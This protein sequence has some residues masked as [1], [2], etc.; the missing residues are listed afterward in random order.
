MRRPPQYNPLSAARTINLL[1]NMR[2]ALRSI[3]I[4]PPDF[5]LGEHR[6]DDFARL[7]LRSKELVDRIFA[8]YQLDFL[9]EIRET[10]DFWRR[11]AE[12]AWQ[13]PRN[14]RASFLFS[15]GRLCRRPC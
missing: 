13:V 4:E 1:H 9:A 3:E 7:G 12:S 14:L 10:D 11:Q 8:A 15:V 2:D 6:Q 5:K